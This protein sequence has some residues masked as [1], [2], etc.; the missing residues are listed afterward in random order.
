MFPDRYFAASFFPNSYFPPGAAATEEL[1]R[2]IPVDHHWRWATLHGPDPLIAEALRI[3][4]QRE[5]ID[6]RKVEASAEAQRQRLRQQLLLDEEDAIMAI[7][8]ADED[9]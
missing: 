8:A 6:Q 5:A 9:L 3:R 1:G 4:K 2:P 7:L